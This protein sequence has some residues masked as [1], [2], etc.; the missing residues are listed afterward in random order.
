MNYISLSFYRKYKTDSEKSTELGAL[1]AK[2]SSLEKTVAIYRQRLRELSENLPRGELE[3]L[4]QRMGIKDLFE[5]PASVET[6]GMALTNGHSPMD[7]SNSTI[8]SSGSTTMDNGNLL[9]ETSDDLKCPPVPSRNN[10][11]GLDVFK[12]NGNGGGGSNGHSKNDELLLNSD[13]DSDFDPRAFESDDSKT[14]NDFFG[15]EPTKSVGQQIFSA[16]NT[17]TSHHNNFVN[18][19]NAVNMSQN[20]GFGASDTNNNNHNMNNGSSTNGIPAP[21]CE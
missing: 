8:S 21:L 5:V 10:L 12:S 17:G 9:I 14:T 11:P 15:F 16:T 18:N 7:R 3:L 4:M 13:S 20:N 1:Q 6:N 19:M 2:N